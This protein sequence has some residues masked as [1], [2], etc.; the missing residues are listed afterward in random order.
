MFWSFPELCSLL[1]WTTAPSGLW[2]WFPL[3]RSYR[4]GSR[5]AFLC[6]ISYYV[7]QTLLYYITQTGTGKFSQIPNTRNLKK[8]QGYKSLFFFSKNHVL[9]LSTLQRGNKSD[10]CMAGAL[11]LLFSLRTQIIGCGQNQFKK[12]QK[13]GNPRILMV[14]DSSGKKC[15]LSLQKATVRWSFPY[16][17]FFLCQLW[18]RNLV[19]RVWYL[20]IF[21]LSHGCLVSYPTTNQPTTACFLLQNKL[22]CI[23][24]M[25]QYWLKNIMPNLVVGRMS[26]IDNSDRQG[27]TTVII[28]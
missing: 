26:W 4:G 11:V 6:A 2:T 13:I 18:Q 3:H 15:C 23:T 9:L 12:C 28:V 14:M 21:D 7:I 17:I 20:T 22:S 8:P 5:T 1:E 24:W 10:I 27:K 25:N 16:F 19:L